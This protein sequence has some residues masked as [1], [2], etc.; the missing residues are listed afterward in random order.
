MSETLSPELQSLKT[1]LEERGVKYAIASFVDIHG[2]CKAKVVPLAHLGQMMSG[3]ELFTGAALDGV[4]Q[5]ISDPEVATMPDPDS[6]TVLPWDSEKVWFASDLYLG[7]RPFDACC[8]SILKQVLA[9]AAEMGYRFNLGIETEFF[10]LKETEQGVLPVSDLDNL[11]KPCYDLQGLLDNFAWVSEIVEAMNQLGWDVYSF[12][13]ED[14]NGQFETDFTYCD[15]LKMADRLTFFR[16][17]VKE[18]ARRH[19]YFAT[20][21]PKPF[22]DRTG[23][24]AHYNMSLADLK[25]GENLFEDPDDPRRCGLSQLGYQFIAGV[26]RHAPAI[27]AVTCPTVNSYKRLV[28]QGSMSGFTWAPVYICYGNNNR[29]NMLRIPMAGGRVECRAA[30]IATNL[31]LGAA[32][33]LAAGLEGIR[34]GLD[35]GE[36]HTENMYEY[37]QAELQEKGIETLPRTLSDA[38]DAFAADPLSKTVMGPLMFDTYVDFKRQEWEDYHSHISD[39][40]IQR[41]LKFF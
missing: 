13:H 36:P 20:F 5:A 11:A 22:S 16:L 2:M 3:S 30:D 17:M 41:Y 24:G 7:D 25:T 15:A 38:I 39:W 12:D 33:I 1:S 29:T 21:M 26:L 37:S 6:A 8:R 28:P 23:S 4:P 31:Y 14:G 9:Q 32:M 19:G 34:E 18:I 27:V 40:E 35:P 10:I